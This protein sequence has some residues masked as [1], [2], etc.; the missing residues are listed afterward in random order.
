M[1]LPFD[2]LLRGLQF[3][4]AGNPTQSVAQGATHV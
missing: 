2:G 1:G 3:K 4:L